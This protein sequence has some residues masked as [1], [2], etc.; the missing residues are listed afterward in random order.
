MSWS[1][2]RW[3]L[4]TGGCTLGRVVET[5]G[6]GF[7]PWFVAIPTVLVLVP[8]ILIVGLAVVLHG[9]K[10]GWSDLVRHRWWTVTGI[11][12]VKICCGCLRDVFLDVISELLLSEPDNYDYGNVGPPQSSIP[13]L[14]IQQHR[15][16]SESGKRSNFVPKICR[17]RRWE[18]LIDEFSNEVIPGLSLVELDFIGSNGCGHEGPLCLGPK[19]ACSGTRSIENLWEVQQDS[20]E[21]VVVVVVVDDE[22]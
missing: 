11:S 8:T 14:S 10:T 4:I 16:L 17:F 20:E 9:R 1:L 21:L 6:V 22:L 2:V 7:A 19:N 13:Y 3:V 12:L 18:E 5:G 15:E